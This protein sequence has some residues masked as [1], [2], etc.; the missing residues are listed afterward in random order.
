MN[1]EKSSELVLSDED[2]IILTAAIVKSAIEDYC[3]PRPIKTS[4]NRKV[5]ETLLEEWKRNKITAR[6]FFESSRLFKLSGLSLS[7][8]I[9][10][11]EKVNADPRYKN[12]SYVR[13]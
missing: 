4:K 10:A 2:A 3:A 12:S 8:L 13:H 9:K 7:Y 5:Y 1:K 6:A 11:Q